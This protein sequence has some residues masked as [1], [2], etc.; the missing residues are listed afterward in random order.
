MLIEFEVGNFLSFNKPV[1]LS[2]VAATPVKEFLTENTFEALKFRLLKSCAIYGANASGKSNLLEAMS[3]MRDFILGSAK[4]TQSIE[5]IYISPFKFDTIAENGPSRFQMIFILGNQQHRYG[6]E[7]DR[8]MVRSE[9]LFQNDGKKEKPLFLRQKDNIEVMRNFEEGKGLEQRTRDNALFLSIVD[10]MNGPTAKNILQWF[11]RFRVIEGLKDERYEKFTIKMLQDQN[12]RPLIL[13]LIRSADLGI[14]DF[15]VDEEDLNV[16]AFKV[17]NEEF[18]KK[19]IDEIGSNKHFRL[20]TFHPKF[21]ENVRSGSAILDFKSEESEGTKKFFRL[22]GPILNC[23]RKGRI[24]VIDE[25]D[26]KLHPLLTRAII[27]LFH[28]PKVNTRNAQL[29]FGTHDTNLL[30][31]GNFRRD[32]VWFTEKNHQAATDLYSLVE[33]KLPKGTKVRNDASFEKDYI[34]G[35]YGAIPFIGNFGKLLNGSEE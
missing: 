16:D 23:L 29:V 2:M 14:E 15:K 5:P 24:V 9:W 27:S 6:F 19:I 13:D 30:C 26:A 31:Y 35:R 1:R 8:K 33:I 17:L 11:S 18:R 21:T 22:A 4:E 28:N 25:L 32:Q 34:H 20:S 3:F 10:Q 12:T 7:V